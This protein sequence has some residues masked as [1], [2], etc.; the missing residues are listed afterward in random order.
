M[1]GWTGGILQQAEH[2]LGGAAPEIANG[3]VHGRE[4]ERFSNGV[5]VEADHR[6]LSG[7]VDLQFTGDLEHPEG[8]LV[9]QTEHGGRTTLRGKGQELAAG[10]HPALDGVSTAALD[11]RFEAGLGHDSPKP[12]E[13][14]R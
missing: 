6:E 14:K 5:A 4:T 9:R 1:A 11:G 7:Y 13:P 12:L 3:L 2:T 10:R 8:H